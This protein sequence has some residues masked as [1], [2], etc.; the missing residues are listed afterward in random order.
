MNID[1]IILWVSFFLSIAM[2]AG[3]MLLIFN[4]NGSKSKH[5]GFKYFQYFIILSYTFG[6]YALWGNIFIQFV[7]FKENL[8]FFS[9]VITVMGIPFLFAGL[10]MQYFWIKSILIKPIRS[11]FYLII[12]AALTIAAM[13]IY[14]NADSL[15]LS[16]VTF[17]YRF[18]A[19]AIILVNGLTLGS[20]KSNWL[21]TP[22]RTFLMTI[23]LLSAAAHVIFGFVKPDHKLDITD[24]FV[25]FLTNTTIAVVFIYWSTAPL[26]V[27][28][29]PGQLLD[30]FFEKYN[31]T[32]RESEIIL[33][34][35][36]G[37][38]N[39]QIA[40][41]LFISLQTVKD[42]THRIYRKTFVKSRSQLSSLLREFK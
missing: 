19:A 13:F 33:E 11:Y 24:T 5:P 15:Q 3:G 28:S 31:I 37:K 30:S 2:V 8:D 6:F 34:I 36:K 41:S 14:F 35:Y 32:Q 16:T 7:P 1:R 10:L 38:T 22:Y 29:P 25:F 26:L 23:I 9:R 17:F 12:I 27:T 20:Y 21:E 39:Q 40:D 18:L 4:K 42:H